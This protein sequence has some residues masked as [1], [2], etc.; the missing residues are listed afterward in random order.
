MGQR[1]VAPGLPINPQHRDAIFS[2]SDRDR[3]RL[4]LEMTGDGVG[5]QL[6]YADTWIIALG[7]MVQLRDHPLTVSVIC[8]GDSVNRGPFATDG[9]GTAPVSETYSPVAILGKIRLEE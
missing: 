6:A 9:D 7:N 5:R 3:C 2:G 1:Q 8:R 4:D